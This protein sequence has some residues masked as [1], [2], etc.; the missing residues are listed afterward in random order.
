M[1]PNTSDLSAVFVY[2]EYPLC[3][4]TFALR[5]MNSFVRELPVV[6]EYKKAEINYVRYCLAPKI[7]EGDKS[8]NYVQPAQSSTSTAASKNRPSGNGRLKLLVAK[9]MLFW[10][11]SMMKQCERCSVECAS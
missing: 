10:F 8:A 9:D 11:F 4:L 2:F 1:L 5:Y 7:E 3:T 6:V